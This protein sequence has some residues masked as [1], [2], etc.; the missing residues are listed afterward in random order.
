MAVPSPVRM[1]NGIRHSLYNAQLYL[2]RLNLIETQVRRDS[3][4]SNGEKRHIANVTF[5]GEVEACHGLPL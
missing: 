3:I 2:A 1:L 4:D 5:Y